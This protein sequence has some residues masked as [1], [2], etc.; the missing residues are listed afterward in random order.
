MVASRLP[1]GQHS[2]KWKENGAPLKGHDLGKQSNVDICSV[3]R[4]FALCRTLQELPHRPGNNKI[5]LEIVSFCLK[6]VMFH[7]K[8]TISEW[9]VLLKVKLAKSTKD[10]FD[11]GLNDW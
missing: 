6:K 8:G 1:Q 5:P 3:Q 7:E 9:L 11:K 4:K 10:V 2:P